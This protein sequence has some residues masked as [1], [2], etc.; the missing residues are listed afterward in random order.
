VPAERLASIHIFIGGCSL[1]APQ[2]CS[3]GQHGC[4]VPFL[5][6]AD[7]RGIGIHL[8]SYF[9]RLNRSYRLSDPSRVDHAPGNRGDVRSDL[10][11][12]HVLQFP[13][14]DTERHPFWE[15]QIGPARSRED[16]SLSLHAAAHDARLWEKD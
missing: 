16:I 1:V 8:G 11:R 2:L 15:L 3:T 12:G 14:L 5:A 10:Q 9:Y 4:N 13:I 7:T 6:R